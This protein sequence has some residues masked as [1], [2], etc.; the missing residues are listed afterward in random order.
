[1]TKFCEK[2]WR[3]LKRMKRKSERKRHKTFCG[4]S[5][6]K[7]Q[8]YFCKSSLYNEWNFAKIRYHILTSA[9]KLSRN[10]CVAMRII[11]IISEIKFCKI[12]KKRRPPYLVPSS[13]LG[14]VKV[15]QVNLLEGLKKRNIH[16]QLF[17]F[18]TF[19]NSF[20]IPDPELRESR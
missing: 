14:V 16:S 19:S 4:R 2:K 12:V 17:F 10:L 8:A 7:K 20:S 5:D 18:T 6:P 15:G 13:P 1:M 11:K 9:S 3:S